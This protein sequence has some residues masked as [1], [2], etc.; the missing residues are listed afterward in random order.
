[1]WKID[2]L[3]QE[4]Q[5]VR[6]NFSLIDLIDYNLLNEDWRWRLTHVWSYLLTDSWLW[7]GKLPELRLVV[8]LRKNPLMRHPYLCFIPRHVNRN[9]YLMFLIFS[10]SAQVIFFLFLV[11]CWRCLL[12]TDSSMFLSVTECNWFCQGQSIAPHQASSAGD[13]GS[14]T[15]KLSASRRNNTVYLCV[16]IFWR[17]WS[18]C[19]GSEWFNLSRDPDSHDSMTRWDAAMRARKQPALKSDAKKVCGKWGNQVREY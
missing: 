2:F 8:L 7:M 11:L 9:V 3:Q 5:M 6:C 12:P 15:V 10:L 19:D 1:M 14:G 17:K 16:P 4:T 13:R 18:W